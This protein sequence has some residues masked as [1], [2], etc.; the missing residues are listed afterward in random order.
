MP[1]IQKNPNG[2]FW[3]SIPAAIIQLYGWNKGD[4]LEFFEERPGVM[5]VRR[6][7]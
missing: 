7:R 3:V 4:T 6:I 1:K 5:A 2:S